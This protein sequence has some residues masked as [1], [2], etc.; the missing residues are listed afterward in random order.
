MALLGPAVSSEVGLRLLLC[1]LGSNVVLR[2]ACCSVGI[3][4]P[5]YNTFKA[6]EN[7]NQDDQK[8]WLLYWAAYGSF[9]IA[10]VFTDKILYWFPFYYHMKFAFLVWLQ[11]P[12]ADGAKH[13]YMRHIRPFLLRHQARL[14]QI[15]GFAYSETAKFLNAHQTEIQFV[16]A[17]FMKIYSSANHIIHPVASRGHNAI[18][19]PPTTQIHS[20]ESDHDD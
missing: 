11:L 20:S 15:A 18:E 3:V 8:K 2:T 5:V 4:F 10:E 12:S 14:D 16:Q 7:N 1:P 19:A 13:L 6:I 17:L 9:S